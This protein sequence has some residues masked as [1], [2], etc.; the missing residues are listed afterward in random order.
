MIDDSKEKS[1]CLFCGNEIINTK[2]LDLNKDPKTRAMLQKEAEAQAIETARAKKQ[3][4]KLNK[5]AKAVSVPPVPETKD[6]VVIRPLPLKTKLT[7]L[8]IFI[9]V[10]LVLTGIFVPTVLSRNEKRDVLTAQL[11]MTMPFEIRES[12]YKFNDNR[13]LLLVTDAEVTET[14]ALDAF[15]KYA[16]LYGKSYNITTSKA[17]GRVTVK[18]FAK[19]GLFICEEKKG[20]AVASFTTST[21]TPTPSPIPA[22]S[23]SSPASV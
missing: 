9:G 23:V 8:G 12:A 15:Q 6:V 13:E 1:K 2:A 14:T 4:Q 7:I 22:P 11:S 10:I 19:N 16:A 21:P 18:L 20:A 17:Q 3:Q 5:E